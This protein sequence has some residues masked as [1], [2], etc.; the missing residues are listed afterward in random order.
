MG[1]LIHPISRYVLYCSSIKILIVILLPSLEMLAWGK[2]GDC[3]TCAEKYD[4]GFQRQHE[5]L[6]GTGFGIKAEHS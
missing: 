3:S 2:S 6:L 1:R 5:A 4:N